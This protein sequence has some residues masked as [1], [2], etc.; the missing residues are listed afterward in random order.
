M[1]YIFMRAVASRERMGV[2]AVCQVMGF[3]G[4]KG[5]QRSSMG[6]SLS[7]RRG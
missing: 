7:R 6:K 2:G 4:R 1:E 3:R 5:R